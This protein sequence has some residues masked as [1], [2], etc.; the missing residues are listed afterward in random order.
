MRFWDTSAIV[1][2][3]I[4]EH[5]TEVARAFF[6]DDSDVV[7]WWGTPLECAAAIARRR[8]E[9]I[10]GPAEQATALRE[11]DRLRTDSYEV[12]PGDSV[13]A[14]AMRVV[15]LHPLRSADALQLAAALQWAGMPAAGT[16]VTFD[17]QLATCA[18][19]E[20]FRV[21]GVE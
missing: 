3:L 15:R 21:V 13:R 12:I 2:L 1:P 4:E 9:G 19:L 10:I 6:A 17:R 7:M 18:E 5:H 16:L 11:L 8:R 14:Q 20:G